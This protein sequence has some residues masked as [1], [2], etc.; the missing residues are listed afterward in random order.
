MEAERLGERVAEFRTDNDRR[1]KTA[2]VLLIVA[3]I[4]L[5][6]GVPLSFTYFEDPWGP[7]GEDPRYRSGAGWLPG[8]LVALG[9][10]FLLIGV[11]LLAKAIRTKGES[12]ELYELGI[13]HRVAGSVSV[14]GWSDIASVRP[15]GVERTGGPHHLGIDFQC[16]LRLTD[17]RKLKFNTYTADASELAAKIDAAVN[18]G[19]RP[20][21]P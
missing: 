16:V 10:M 3:A 17:G 6:I 8:G 5:G 4:G 9:L 19:T 11:P 7:A 20:R 18:G 12:Y 13:R 14:I 2:L 15:Q 1:R 21:R